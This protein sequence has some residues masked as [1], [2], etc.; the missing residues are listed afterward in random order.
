MRCET[1]GTCLRDTV[2]LP[3]VI[4]APGRSQH[5]PLRP[6]KALIGNLRMT[7]ICF[8][9][10]LQ[11]SLS[12]RSVYHSSICVLFHSSVHR[13]LFESLTRDWLPPKTEEIR[14][15][16]HPQAWARN[17]TCAFVW[18][19]GTV[20]IVSHEDSSYVPPCIVRYIFQGFYAQ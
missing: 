19:Q 18:D 5:R 15:N 20:H 6:G 9:V 1:T 14:S 8:S 7:W 16:H 4:F 13:Q 11:H 2:S 3:G 17:R 10:C 12:C